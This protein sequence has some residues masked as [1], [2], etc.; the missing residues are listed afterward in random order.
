MKKYVFLVYAQ[1]D[2]YE[3]GDTLIR[4]FFYDD[5]A[6]KFLGRLRD[7]YA[8]RPPWPDKEH[9]ETEEQH[10]VRYEAWREKERRWLARWPKDTRDH[11]NCGSYRMDTVVLHEDAAKV[12]KGK[13]K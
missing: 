2:S 5:E 9:D 4:A 11:A 12:R 8:Q 13:T 10:D 3:G 7:L 1:N 6:E